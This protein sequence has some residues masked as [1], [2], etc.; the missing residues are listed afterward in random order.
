MNKRIMNALGFSAEVEMVENHICP[1]CG[2]DVNPD[3]FIGIPALREFR[4]SGLC[5][6]CQ[7]EIFT[8]ED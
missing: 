1:I 4:I 8:D 5:Q 6:S 2:V 7:N 3:G